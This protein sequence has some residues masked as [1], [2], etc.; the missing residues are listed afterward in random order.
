LVDTAAALV[1]TVAGW[2]AIVVAP[3][4]W[5][6]PVV[7]PRRPVMMGWLRATVVVLLGVVWSLGWE[8]G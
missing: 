5:G 1:L 6:R 3:A 4:G 2:S 7:R 8:L